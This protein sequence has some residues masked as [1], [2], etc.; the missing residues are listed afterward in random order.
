MKAILITLYAMWAI[1]FLSF[2]TCALCKWFN[3]GFN[4][5]VRDDVSQSGPLCTKH[6]APQTPFG[7]Q[8]RMSDCRTRG[9]SSNSRNIKEIPRQNS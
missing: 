8:H 4:K 9:F 7:S 6:R 5:K 2:G 3:R 1:L